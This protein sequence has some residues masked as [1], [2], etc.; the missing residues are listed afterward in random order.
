MDLNV[1]YYSILG[2]PKDSSLQEIK[3]SYY[4][5]SFTHH[6]DKG[7]SPEVFNSITEAYNVLIDPELHKE[8]DRKSKFGK[9]YDEYEEFFIINNEF[10]YN[11]EKSKLEKFKKEEILDI[12][13][14][15]DPETFKDTIEYERLVT[16]R[17]CKGSGRDTESKI[18]IKDENGNVKGI[19]DSDDGCDFCCGSGVDH[20]GNT[21]SF[22]LGEGVI[23]LNMCKVCKGKRRI[24]GKQKLSKI[25]LE[26]K[27]ETRIKNM[28]NFSTMDPSKVGDLVLVNSRF[29]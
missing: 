15:V 24:A 20:N 2:V 16:C 13:I 23:G 22:C 7:G 19:F 28:G 11:K 21:C 8:Y 25:K 10:D 4:K 26:D 17:V 6:P 29:T 12:Y 14:K 3:K 18:V 1:N 5:L 9:D 27:K